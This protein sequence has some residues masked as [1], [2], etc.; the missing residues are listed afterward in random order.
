MVLLNSS[1]GRESIPRIGRVVT[2]KG[3]SPASGND[4]MAAEQPDGGVRCAIPPYGSMVLT[5]LKSKG[6]NME[7]TTFFIPKWALAT[8]VTLA[9]SGSYFVGTAQAEKQP[10]MHA[11]LK[12]LHNAEE[13]LNKAT[14]DKGGHRVKALEHVR[15]AIAEV[16]QGVA[17]DNKHKEEPKKKP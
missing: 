10:H 2:V 7:R 12:A 14:H 3:L 4:Y 17:Y 15:A 13:Q 11:A 9:L 8:V 6:G 1:H 16:K 5:T